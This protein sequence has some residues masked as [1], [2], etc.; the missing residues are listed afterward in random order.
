MCTEAFRQ[1]ACALLASGRNVR[2]VAWFKRVEVVGNSC[3]RTIMRMDCRLGFCEKSWSV[4]NFLRGVVSGSFVAD[5][6]QMPAS[7]SDSYMGIHRCVR[8]TSTT[9]AVMRYASRIQNI[10]SSQTGTGKNID[11]CYLSDIFKTIL[12]CAACLLSLQYK[13]NIKHLANAD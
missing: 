8:G 6:Q 2:F 5:H 11:T 13:S 9:R 3:S 4:D 7:T 1:P 12:A 10:A